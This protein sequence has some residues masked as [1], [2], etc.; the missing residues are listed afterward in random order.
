MIRNGIRQD[1]SLSP[2]L[3]LFKIKNTK[4]QGIKIKRKLIHSEK[5]PVDITVTKDERDLKNTLTNYYYQQENL[6]INAKRT[7][8]MIVD[9][10]DKVMRIEKKLSVN[11]VTYRTTISIILLF[12]YLYYTGQ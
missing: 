10:R 6:K 4:I 9:K 8:I 3:F 12:N 7:K 5:F 2:I 1:C 11:K